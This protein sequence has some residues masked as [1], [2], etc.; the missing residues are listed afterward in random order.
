MK[1]IDPDP[2]A[3]SAALKSLPKDKPVV[4][5]NLLAFRDQAAYAAGSEE[6]SAPCTG[7]EAY[8]RYSKLAIKHVM[9]C[10][11]EVIFMGAAQVPLVA[12]ADEK[13]D[14]VLLVRYPSI[15]AFVA[16][17]MNPEYQQLSRHRTAALEEARLIP[18]L[19]AG[20]G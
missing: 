5:L 8:A 2:G 7:R 9:G 14:E 18:M 16:M 20:V 12:P 1:P 3:F 15:E 10:G 19:E 4:M 6:S 13:W 11:G 17:V